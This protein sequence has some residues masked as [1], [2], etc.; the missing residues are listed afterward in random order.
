MIINIFSQADTPALYGL[1]EK[2]INFFQAVVTPFSAQLADF[3]FD[4]LH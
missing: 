3:Q 4:I 1:N 2:L